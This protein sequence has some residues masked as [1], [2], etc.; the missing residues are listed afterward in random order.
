MASILI[1]V[2]T[3][4]TKIVFKFKKNYGVDYFEVELIKNNN[5]ACRRQ[6]KAS[7]CNHRLKVKII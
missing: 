7:A 6:K 5:K 1:G 3:K 4:F 2:V